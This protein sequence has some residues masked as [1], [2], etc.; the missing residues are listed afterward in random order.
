MPVVTLI[1]DLGLRD[2]TAG[3]ARGIIYT[4]LP[5]ATI[6]DISHEVPPF[7]VAHAAWLLGS[8]C[9]SFPPHT[10]HLVLVDALYQAQPQMLLVAIG[11][12]YILA[13]A[14]GVLS[15]LS[16]VAGTQAWVV[17][18]GAPGQGLLQWVQAAVQ[19][20]AQLQAAPATQYG[21][22]QIA[23][24][25]VLPQPVQVA[26]DAILC[27]VQYI[28]NFG[29]LITNLSQQ[30]FQAVGANRPFRITVGVEVITRI[31]TACADVPKGDALCRFNSRGFLQV[32]VNKGNAASLLGF[33]IGG[34]YNHI[35]IQFG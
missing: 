28:D 9:H 2:A 12:Q 20:V 7:Q 8:V 6:V 19:V 3:I 21:W 25:Q 35:K 23:I 30:Q 26:N 22:P 29:N 4:A 24:P 1:S 31:A 15:L 5:A 14:N 16:A 10:V 34:I 18:T 11:Q 17:H 27:H 13:P 32:C 33:R